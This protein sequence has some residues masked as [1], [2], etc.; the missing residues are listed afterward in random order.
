LYL[1][2]LYKI[3]V[4]RYGWTS[5]Q[6]RQSEGEQS[7][8]DCCKEAIR[9]VKEAYGTGMGVRKLQLWNKVFRIEK[10]IL[11]KLPPKMNLRPPFLL[12]NPMEAS[13]IAV[14]VRKNLDNFS[15]ED[16][17]NYILDELMIRMAQ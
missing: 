3:A 1:G 8:E 5:C 15:A 11:C 2:R 7:W 14:W 16:L 10:R 17:S 4:R 6:V 9:K 12:N 13:L